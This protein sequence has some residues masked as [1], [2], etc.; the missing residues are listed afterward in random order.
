MIERSTAWHPR[1]DDSL[2]QRGVDP[3]PYQCSDSEALLWLDESHLHFGTKPKQPTV[4][5]GDGGG[6][7]TSTPLKGRGETATT[8]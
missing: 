4:E 1:I 3:S 7:A 6:S 8:R 5:G 2:E